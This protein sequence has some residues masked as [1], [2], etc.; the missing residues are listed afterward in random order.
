M[1][2]HATLNQFWPHIA[3]GFYFAAGL[4]ATA[5]ALLY[6][7]DSRAAIIWIS[8]IWTLPGAGP[9]LPGAGR[10]PHPPPRP[11]IGRP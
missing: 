4:L 8:I 6:K 1:N 3:A 10:Q 9:A 11:A 5:H 2:W 7:R